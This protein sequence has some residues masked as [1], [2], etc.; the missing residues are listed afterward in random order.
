MYKDYPK[1]SLLFAIVFLSLVGIPPLSG[2]WPKINLISAA[3]TTNNYALLIGIIFASFV[4]LIMVAKIWA[5]IFWKDTPKAEVDVIKD[6]TFAP[7]TFIKK[8]TLVF[9]IVLLTCVTLY[10]GFNAERVI[11]ISSRIA[12]EMM[13]TSAYIEAVMQQSQ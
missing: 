7:L 5:E 3:F 10:L 12:A 9:P 13:D 8:I 11:Q 4:T 6:D 2:F 1:L